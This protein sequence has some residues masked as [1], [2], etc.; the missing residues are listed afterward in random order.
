MFT[1]LNLSDM[2]TCYKV[3]RR[4]IIQSIKTEV[5]G[6]DITEYNPD[7]DFQKMT[8]FLAAKM[9]KEIIGKMMEK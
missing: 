8:A 5:I 2:E 7:R 4:D 3:F 6:A 9:M 1:D